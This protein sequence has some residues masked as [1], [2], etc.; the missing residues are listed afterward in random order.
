VSFFIG[1]TNMAD[2][3]KYAAGNSSSTTLSTGV[4]DNETS[5]PLTS[6]TN[7][8]SKS[9]EG[10]VILSEGENVEEF[11]Y[12]TGKTGGALTIPLDNRGLEG[13]SAQTHPSGAT[14]KGIIT[15]G[16]WNDVIDSLA[17]IVDKTTGNIPGTAVIDDDTGATVS[18]TSL[19]VSESIKAYVDTNAS[20]D[21][22]LE[23][24]A[25]TY[26]SATTFTASGDLTS[27]YQPGDKIK[28]TQSTG[29]VKYWPIIGV[30]HSGGTTTFTIPANNDYTL[31]NEAITDPFY[32]KVENPQGWPDWFA[33]DGN[34]QGFSGLTTD[35]HK[36]KVS[37]GEVHFMWEV[38]GTSNATTFTMTAPITAADS[39]INIDR[40]AGLVFDNNTTISGAGRCSLTANSSTINLFKDMASG[41]WTAS[42]RKRSRGAMSYEYKQA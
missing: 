31:V 41:A 15:A 21:G 34:S 29:G 5:A 26:A 12:A 6:D 19:W 36:F 33:Y 16:M 30:A 37:G 10:M 17:K 14:V 25:I 20:S 2:K 13:G 42:S 9:G 22:W 24:D 1:E 28:L 39:G 7:F 35:L 18:D 32:S 38:D 23:A 27:K 11:A 40:P 4:A 3:L 8:N